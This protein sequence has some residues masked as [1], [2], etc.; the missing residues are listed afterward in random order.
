MLTDEWSHMGLH[1]RPMSSQAFTVATFNIHHAEGKDKALDLGRIAAAISALEPD[2]VAL[3][4]LDVGTRRTRRADQPA[5]LADLL[6]MHLYFAPAFNMDPGEYGIG[7]AAREEFKAMVEPLPKVGD[8]E[9]RVAIVASWH[10]IGVVTTH[11]SRNAKA[12]KL[13][14]EH[15]AEVTGRLGARS[16]VMGD[17]NQ[18]T[19]SLGALKR[20]GLTPVKPKMP[21][22]GILKPGW[23]IDHILTGPGVK[24]SNARIIATNASDH[25]LLVAS[26]EVHDS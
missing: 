5:E 14:I 3:Q 7:L 2:L 24:A 20:Q 11:L 16:L 13:Q 6:G 4:E 9:P 26:I 19:R 21:L 8:E 12:R 17:L 22:A 1:N 18:P 15:I 10:G 25:P 23:P